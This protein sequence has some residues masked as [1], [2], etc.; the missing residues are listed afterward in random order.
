MNTSADSN[1]DNGS[2][3][4]DDDLLAAEYV[5]GVQDELARRRAQQ[6]IAD[7]AAFA[8]QVGD[9]E[10]RFAP[11][12]LRGTADT[13]PSPRVW[14]A[15]RERLGWTVV[16][17]TGSSRGVWNNVA[18]WRTAAA[19]A[20]GAGL[21]AV[22]FD[23]ARWPARTPTAEEQAASPVTVLA[24]G[25]G[26]PGWIARIDAA[27]GEVLMVPV[28][29][30]ADASGRVNELWIIPA[31]GKPLSLGFLSHEKAHTIAVPEDVRASLIVGAT[32]AV[33]LEDQAGIPHAA[34]SGQPI[35]LG[36]IRTI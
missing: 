33:T 19:I 22:T 34:P 31:G 10:Q 27:R 23:L 3:P 18:F 21:I 1:H 7:D 20:I 11:W 2:A 26:T 8:R 25:D 36:S 15:V 5:L 30:A 6:R 13:A 32:L 16:A 12:L 17:P 35:A 14:E 9:W 28:P 29:A 4:P 24:R